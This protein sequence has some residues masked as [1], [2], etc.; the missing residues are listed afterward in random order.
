MS[1]NPKS[2][3]DVCINYVCNNIEKLFMVDQIGQTDS[4]RSEPEYK[5]INSNVYLPMEISELLLTKLSIQN[6][7]ND[8]ILSVFNHKNVYLRF[9]Y[10]IFIFIFITI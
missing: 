7:L 6:K 5:F 8:E 1:D 10:F 3:K 4:H 9:V 2:L